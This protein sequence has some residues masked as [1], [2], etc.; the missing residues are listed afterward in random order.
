VHRGS[1]NEALPSLLLI[2]NDTIQCARARR[3]CSGGPPFDHHR[4]GYSTVLDVLIFQDRSA[5]KGE[6]GLCIPSDTVV[7][8]YLCSDWDFLSIKYDEQFSH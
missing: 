3:G 2:G 5:V 8:V 6:A 4:S 1:H 7:C